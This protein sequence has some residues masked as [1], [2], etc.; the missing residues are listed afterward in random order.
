MPGP[1]GHV[2]LAGVAWYSDVWWERHPNHLVIQRDFWF[3]LVLVFNVKYALSKCA[4]VNTKAGG[5]CSFRSRS[6]RLPGSMSP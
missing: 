6:Q 1:F 2:R 4:P 5:G 3:G